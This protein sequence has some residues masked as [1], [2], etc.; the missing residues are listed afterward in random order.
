MA[1]ASLDFTQP[2]K[3]TTEIRR[4]IVAALE[5][6]CDELAA[7]MAREL[8]SEVQLSLGDASQRTWAQA[9]AQLPV[10]SVAVAVHEGAIERSMLLSVET[11]LVLQSLECMLGG[12]AALA[13][14]ERRLSELDWKLATRLLDT[15]V[16]ELSGAWCELGASELTRGV[17]DVE[18]DAGVVVLPNEPTLAVAFNSTIAGQASTMSL[19]IPWPIVDPIS[20][21]LRGAAPAGQ[22]LHP[23]AAAPGPEALAR[24]VASAHVLLRAEVSSAQM[25]IVRLLE[26]APGELVE[27]EGRAEDGVRL[28]AEGISIGCGRPGRSGARRAIKLESTDEAPVRADTYATLGRAELER[29]RAHV[30]AAP[31]GPDGAILSTIFVRVWAELGRTHMGIGASLELAPGAV[32][33][34]DQL[35]D[36][37][38]ELF[39][40][41]LCFANGSLVVTGEGAW[42]VQLEQLL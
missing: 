34:L 32:V 9:K 22:S 3:F 24:G 15:I 40:N 12:E 6:F 35:A 17:L 4:R 29:A 39:A 30:A 11:A 31:E 14:V 2:T 8:S 36:E 38:V 16:G 7:W 5:P 10:D 33:E 1:I 37:P 41:G 21:S 27:L 13:P 25:G 19:L 20:A 23:Q 42:G 28:F 26:L 18:G